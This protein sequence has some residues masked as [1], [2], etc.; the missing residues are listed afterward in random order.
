MV[1]M[2][3]N[4]GFAYIESIGLQNLPPGWIMVGDRGFAYDALKYPNFNRHITP[5]FAHKDSEQFT[6]EELQADK[7]LC[8]LRYIS[9][10]TFARVTR[11]TG[12][13]LL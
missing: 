7:I 11:D 3:T 6:Q 10:T 2:L 12:G 8:S 4:E 1:N 5:H 13:D 9:E